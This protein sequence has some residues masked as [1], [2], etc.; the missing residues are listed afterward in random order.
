MKLLKDISSFCNTWVE[1]SLALLGITM[2]GVVIL[3]VIFRYALNN[4]LFWSEELAR[5]I[6]VWITFLGAS[7]AYYR[8]V[9][10][11]IDLLTNRLNQKTKFVLEIG[12]H[13]IS[14][15]LF[16]VMIYQGTLFSYFVRTQISPAMAIPKWII[17]SV[18]PLSG[19]LFSLHCI[20]FIF[21]TIARKSHHDC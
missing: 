21:S 3:Q 4:S 16:G 5:Y 15:C 14:L 17:F 12:V 19:L 8:K 10:P 9:H 6:L 18:I 11:G 2:A 13:A 1:R 7:C 20:T